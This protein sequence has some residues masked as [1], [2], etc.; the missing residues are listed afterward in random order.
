MVTLAFKHHSAMKVSKNLLT[1][2][3]LINVIFF[4]FKY[5]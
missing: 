1:K 4:T 3:Q 5:P 2:W